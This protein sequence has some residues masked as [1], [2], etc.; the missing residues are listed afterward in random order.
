MKP[1]TKTFTASQR[2]ATEKTADPWKKFFKP[3]AVDR[4]EEIE[5]TARIMEVQ[6]KH[7][8][9][10]LVLENVVG[11]AP[12]LKVTAGKPTKTWSLTVLVDKKVANAKVAK[13]ETVPAEIDGVPTDVVEVGELVPHVFNAEVRPALPG[14]SIG[15]FDITAGTFGCLVRDIR[16]CCC[17]QEKDCHC[18]PAREECPGDYLILSNNHVLANT[19]QAK[20]GDLILQPGAF[21]GGIYPSD[22]VATLERFEP[23]V[24]SF[25]NGYNLVDAAVARPIASRNV[26]SSIIG[27]VMPVGINQAFVGG[28]VI[29]A[30][31]TTQVTTGVVL[32]VNATVIVNYG[33]GLAVFRHQIITT[34]MSAGG[35]SGSLL[36]D[37][38]LNA[39]GLLYAGSSEITIHN[40]IADVETALGVRP[41][42]A[43]RSS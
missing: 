36:M 37:Q 14:Y 31:R 34:A 3:G 19:N 16:R 35:D 38:N 21:D 13:A 20:P 17:K 7:E 40:H 42:T 33:V 12:S 27:Q 22:A 5:Q 10:L 28:L 30:G 39:V 25:P 1:R 23:I 24:F 29:K 2:S 32:S 4:M 6:D 26:T 41:L 9:E 15:H 11:V 43:T 18:G 8:Q